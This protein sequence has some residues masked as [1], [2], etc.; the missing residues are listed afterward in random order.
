MACA[1]GLGVSIGTGP[2]MRAERPH[3]KVRLHDPDLLGVFFFI[4]ERRLNEG[5]ASVRT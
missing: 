5:V 1:D 4:A 3:R 2:A